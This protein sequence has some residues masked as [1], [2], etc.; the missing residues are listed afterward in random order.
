[1]EM[2]FNISC[3]VP[4]VESQSQTRMGI[5]I[6]RNRERAEAGVALAVTVQS[7]L[8]MRSSESKSSSF[9]LTDRTTWAGVSI[10]GGFFIPIHLF[11]QEQV[12]LRFGYT[13]PLAELPPL[14]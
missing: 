5:G 3:H 11:L 9:R 10:P 6:S 13:E 8:R 2:R 14:K 12:D 4:A 7:D 1:M